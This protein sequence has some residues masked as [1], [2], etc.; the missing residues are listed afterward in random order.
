VTAEAEVAKLNRFEPIFYGGRPRL[1]PKNP[2]TDA[3]TTTSS[4]SSN[5]NS[6][7]A[8]SYMA[9]LTLAESQ[10]KHFELTISLLEKSQAL[11]L[12]DGGV[13]STSATA[14]SYESFA[15]GS[16]FT[17]N[18]ASSSSR[19]LCLFSCLLVDIFNRFHLFLCLVVVMPLSVLVVPTVRIL[20]CV[21]VS[22]VVCS[23]ITLCSHTH[24]RFST[25]EWSSFAKPIW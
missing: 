19:F 21:C 17:Y 18:L 13:G 23:H 4:S 7:L 5:S 14:T 6:T 24:C 8:T 20:L 25:S 11:A 9:V 1:E 3:S 16:C 10:I 22:Q 12:I 15:R 2:S